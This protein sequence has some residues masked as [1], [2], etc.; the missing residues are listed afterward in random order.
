MTMLAI[1]DHQSGV[2]RV[3]YYNNKRATEVFLGL[4][5]NLRFYLVT[6]QGKNNYKFSDQ[7]LQTVLNN[8]V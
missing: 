1:R 8:F 2:S 4:T 7:E 6:W 5:S 3:S